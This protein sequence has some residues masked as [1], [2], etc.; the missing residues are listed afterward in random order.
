[1][2]VYPKSPVKYN[3]DYGCG[4]YGTETYMDDCSY[5]FDFKDGSATK[6][7]ADVIAKELDNRGYICSSATPYMYGINVKT[8]YPIPSNVKDIKGYKFEDYSL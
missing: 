5:W 4:V 3:W 2:L 6:E 8:V 1:M 7:I